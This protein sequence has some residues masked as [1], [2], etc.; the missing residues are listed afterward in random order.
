M[1]IIKTILLLLCAYTVTAQKPQQPFEGTIRYL[2]EDGKNTNQKEEV[3]VMFRPWRIRVNNMMKSN[4]DGKYIILAMDSLK[5][6]T[7]YTGTREYSVSP[8]TLPDAEPPLPQTKTVFGYKTKL[9]K[10]NETLEQGNLGALLNNAK[11]YYYVGED[12]YYPVP[13]RL[14][15]STVFFFIKDDLIAIDAMFNF[16]SMRGV[17]NGI[18]SEPTHFDLKLEATSIIPQKLS[19]DLFTIPSGYTERTVWATGTGTD[20]T[21]VDT[22]MLDEN[23]TYADTVAIGIPTADPPAIVPVKPVPPSKKK[24]KGKTSARKP[25]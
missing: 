3:Q 24:T 22:I 10:V 7:I 18:E 19:Q 21:M 12:L 4:A 25:D 16:G 5:V 2:V 23:D 9:I 8:I 20:T 17:K 6:Y 14:K 15:N 1:N 11:Q 13:A